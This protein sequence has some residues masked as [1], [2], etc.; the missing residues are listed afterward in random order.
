MGTNQIIMG[1]NYSYVVFTGPGSIYWFLNV[2]NPRV[3]HGKEV[4]RY[5]AEDELR[6]AEEHFG[7]QLNEHD[8]FGDV[9][10]SRRISRLT[11]LHEYQWKRWHFKRVTTIGD[12]AHK[13]RRERGVPPCCLMAFVPYY[14]ASYL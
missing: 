11:P 9:Y 5:T 2:K 7:D 1:K 12:A 4:P 14:C 6:L 13:V 3:T 10:K 8:T